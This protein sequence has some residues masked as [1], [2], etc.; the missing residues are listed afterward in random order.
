MRL[1]RPVLPE[2]AGVG[3]LAEYVRRIVRV[4][5][6]NQKIADNAVSRNDD[7]GA[8]KARVRFGA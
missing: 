4:L 7:N 3:T 5:N 6:D 1:I 2:F 8:T